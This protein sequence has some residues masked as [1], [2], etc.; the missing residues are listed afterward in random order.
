MGYNLI[1]PPPRTKF[2]K[3]MNTWGGI[4]FWGVLIVMAILIILEIF[5]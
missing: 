3:A 5:K 2:D 4:V 1:P